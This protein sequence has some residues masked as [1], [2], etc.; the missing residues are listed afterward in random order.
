MAPLPGRAV[1][2]LVRLAY[3]SDQCESHQHADRSPLHVR[4]EYARQYSSL[5]FSFYFV[6]IL[7]LFSSVQTFSLSHT[8]P[9]LNPIFVLLHPIIFDIAPPPTHKYCRKIERVLEAPRLS[10]LSQSPTSLRTSLSSWQTARTSRTSS[11]RACRCA[12]TESNGMLA[13]LIMPLV[14]PYADASAPLSATP[15]SSRTG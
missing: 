1:L 4:E 2:T 9:S 12:P 7:F 8:R 5:F 15:S 14:V 3:L 6:F 11:S 10:E 13:V